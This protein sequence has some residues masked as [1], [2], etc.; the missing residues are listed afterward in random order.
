[1]PSTAPDLP[2]GYVLWRLYAYGIRVATVNGVRLTYRQP[3]P[4]Y[5]G[6]EYNPE[7]WYA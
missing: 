1:M 5:R 6:N 4:G 3:R 7:Y 2:L